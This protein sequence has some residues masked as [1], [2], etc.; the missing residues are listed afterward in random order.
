[1]KSITTTH[2]VIVRVSDE[3]YDYLNQFTW[4]SQLK[5][6]KNYEMIY[7]YFFRWERTNEVDV[8][9][10]PK[11]KR[12]FMHRE[13]VRRKLG[14]QQIN[15]FIDH[16]DLD[17]TNNTRENLRTCTQRQNNTNCRPKNNKQ[18]KGIYQWINKNGKPSKWVARIRD[19]NSKMLYLG[20]YE[21]PIDAA[22]A[23]DRAAREINKEFAYCNFNI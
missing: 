4:S 16:K 10:K 1:M 14:L 23:Y 15:D 21:D 8:H 12:V 17:V 7:K 5:D 9:G 11:Y 13:V 22:K 19:F 20:S 2:G 18:F 3:D 6:T